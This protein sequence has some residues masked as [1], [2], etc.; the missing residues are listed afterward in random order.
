MNTE[1]KDSKETRHPVD[2][3]T[4]VR[5]R[6]HH[7]RQVL[8]DARFAAEKH[9]DE[10]AEHAFGDACEWHEAH[11]VVMVVTAALHI[12]E[13]AEDEFRRVEAWEEERGPLAVSN[14]SRDE[15]RVA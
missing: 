8:Q 9:G 2:A 7:S 5:D 12:L 1:A 14:E 13:V 10:W 4:F 11:P 3:L 15:G 6:T